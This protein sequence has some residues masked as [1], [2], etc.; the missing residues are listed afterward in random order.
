MVTDRAKTLW[1]KH[2]ALGCLGVLL[3]LLWASAPASAKP[4]KATY[5]GYTLP[6]S[7]A[8]NADYMRL[9]LVDA[10]ANKAFD[11]DTFDMKKSSATITRNKMLI[12][13]PIAKVVSQQLNKGQPK[14]GFIDFR[15]K[16]TTFMPGDLL[17]FSL[18]FAGEVNYKTS[19]AQWRDGDGGVGQNNT[20]GAAKV[21]GAAGFFDTQFDLFDDLDLT[22]FAP[23]G[24]FEIR[25]L[26]FLTDITSSQ[27]AALST[28]AIQEGMFPPGSI[29]MGAFDLQSSE[30]SGGSLPAY[31]AFNNPWQEEPGDNLWDVALGQL[32]DPS[33]GALSAFVDGYEGA[34]EPATWMMALLGLA[35]TGAVLRHR[36]R[37]PAA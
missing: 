16:G 20:I 4:I 1:V 35:L 37:S 25:N 14:P 23:P 2:A 19:G 32:Y 11:A 29:Q 13:V 27:L 30:Y 6:Y 24:D 5:L 17:S 36:R 18:Y 8:A 33:T 28:V 15:P 34:P 10:N 12:D 31:M 22:Q 9:N 21:S 3:G 7:P 26:T